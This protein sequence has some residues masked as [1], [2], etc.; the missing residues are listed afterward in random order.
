M[1]HFCFYNENL[2]KLIYTDNLLDKE[3][4]IITDSAIGYSLY[5]IQ[6]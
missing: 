4:H 2:T 3:E 6:L 5:D 1:L